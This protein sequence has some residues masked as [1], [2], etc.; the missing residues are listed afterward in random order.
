MAKVF[1][2]QPGG[3]KD[4]GQATL[5]EEESNKLT[6]ISETN[7]EHDDTNAGLKIAQRNKIAAHFMRVEIPEPITNEI[8]ENRGVMFQPGNEDIKTNLGNVLHTI[9]KSFIKHNYNHDAI[10]IIDFNLYENNT[11][12]QDVTLTD[13]SVFQMRMTFDDEGETVFQWG[14]KYDEHPLRPD[15]F[16]TVKSERGMLLIYPNYVKVIEEKNVKNYME[17]NGKYIAQDNE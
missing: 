9:A 13:G 2:L 5:N 14:D 3:L 11:P 10:P 1:D 4:G 16:E 8:W 12:I 6:K 15:T 7:K 17:V